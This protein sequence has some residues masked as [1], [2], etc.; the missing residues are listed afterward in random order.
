MRLTKQTNYA[1]RM[2]MYCASN[3]EALSRIPEIANTYA[4]SEL[5]LFKILQPLVEAGFMKTVRGRNGGVKLA[6][7]A[8]EISVAD[9]IKITEDNFSMAECFDNQSSN[10]PL[11][12]FCGLN[13]VLKKAL[14]SFFDVLSLTS[15]ADL[16][17][18]SSQPQFKIDKGKSKQLTN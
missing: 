4:V 8:T 14:D 2:L 5:F 11:I 7:P 1:L 10:C 16:Q 17:L 18:L 6:K 15:I 13:I 3:Q 12:N 9:V